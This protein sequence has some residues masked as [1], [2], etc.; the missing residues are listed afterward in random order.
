MKSHPISLAILIILGVTSLTTVAQ[1]LDHNVKQNIAVPLPVD[2]GQALKNKPALKNADKAREAHEVKDM[3]ELQATL[4]NMRQ[5]QQTRG[6]GTNT[7]TTTPLGNNGINTSPSDPLH[8]QNNTNSTPLT[9]QALQDC[10]HSGNPGV[11]CFHAGHQQH[12]TMTTYQ[13][14][15]LNG[16]GE[17]NNQS[18]GGTPPT[19][20]IGPSK[21]AEHDSTTTNNSNGSENKKETGP[22]AEEFDHGR[23]SSAA[24]IEVQTDMRIESHGGKEPPKGDPGA[25]GYPEPVANQKPHLVRDYNS[26]PGTDGGMYGSLNTTIQGCRPDGG[27]CKK[28]RGVTVND[29]ISRPG[30]DQE[31]TSSTSGGFAGPQVEL[32][33]SAVSNPDENHSA[34]G[35]Q[36]GG[37]VPQPSSGG[38]GGSEG[39]FSGTPH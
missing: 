39:G 15:P 10:I 25:D 4:Q 2:H 37:I 36:G 28:T 29:K 16:F 22:T 19:G 18:R 31:D 5:V 30:P 14:N 3:Q 24:A 20:N 27:P 34:N 9:G 35:H 17:G 26:Q 7:I 8:N 23:E 6:Q 13:V 38:A 21:P 1:P 32:R 11:N 33:T 12:S